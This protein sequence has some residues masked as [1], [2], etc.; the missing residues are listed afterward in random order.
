[1]GKS[2]SRADGRTDGRTDGAVEFQP[3]AM[4][5]AMTRLS[6]ISHDPRE[7]RTSVR[8]RQHARF[9]SHTWLLATAV[10]N[11]CIGLSVAI[12]VQTYRKSPTSMC[13][14]TVYGIYGCEL[15]SVQCLCGRKIK[16]SRSQHPCLA[17]WTRL[18]SAPAAVWDTSQP[19]R[20][21]DSACASACARRRNDVTRCNGI[22]IPPYGR[23]RIWNHP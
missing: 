4:G 22:D 2:G 3:A 12:G 5:R 13:L 1:M 16:V 21:C 20:L 19:V 23:M 6:V 11:W 14:W 7:G 15:R 17:Q 8:H 18:V 10:A 9:A